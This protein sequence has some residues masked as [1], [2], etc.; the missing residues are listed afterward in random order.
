MPTPS[1]NIEYDGGRAVGS[2]RARKLDDDRHSLA[3]RARRFLLREYW[4]IGVVAQTVAD[5]AAHGIVT[6]VKWLPVPAPGTFLADPCCLQHQDGGHTLFAEYLDH[7]APRG[8]IWAAHL[9][10]G[11]ALTQ[12]RFAPLLGGPFHMSYP[13]AFVHDRATYLVCESWQAGGI[14]LWQRSSGGWRSLPM[15]LPGR[16]AV[17][18]TLFHWQ[19]R[20]WLFCTFQ[21]DAPDARLHVF[22]AAAPTGPWVAHRA[23]PVRIDGAGARPAGPIFVHD[24]VPVRPG[25]DCS[26]TY[27]GAVVLNAV[28]RLTPDEYEERP[29]RRL[30][31]VAGAHG[32]GLHTIATAG[33]MTLIDGKRWGMDPAPPGRQLAARMRTLWRH[34]MRRPAGR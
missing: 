3:E 8:E 11:T 17:D 26:R 5:I 7:R 1:K 23:N 14:P 15:L 29:L 33:A 27:G 12:A 22:H 24:G 30:A 25:Q 21:D 4:T 20:W 16:A 34:A 18:P 32:R 2:A 13:Q 31:P 28:T 19:G 6:P 9:A 10:P